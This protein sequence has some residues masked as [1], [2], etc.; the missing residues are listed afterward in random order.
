MRFFIMKKN[1]KTLNIFKIFLLT[2]MTIT[3]SFIVHYT[4][5]T[6]GSW[7]QLNFITIVLAAYFFREKGSILVA[8]LSGIILGPF[9]PNNR[10][11]NIVQ[12]PSNWLFRIFIYIFIAYFVSFIF[13]QNDKLNKKI[14]DSQYINQ[15]TGLY[16][17]NKLIKDLHQIILNNECFFILF[18]KIK[19]LD[20]ISKYV[21]SNIIDE[22]I[23][24]GLDKAKE[25]YN[26][27]YIYSLNSDEY[28][29]IVKNSNEKD[30][31][32]Q[33]NF[34]INN[35]RKPIKANNHLISLVIKV[36]LLLYNG[37]K[38][39]EIEL[40]NRVKIAADQGEFYE[41]GIYKYDYQLKKEKIFFHEISSSLNNS[42]INNEMYLVYQPIV[43]INEN[44]ISSSEVLIRWNRGEKEAVG[45]NIF[46]KIAEQTG[47]INT[48]T[49]WITTTSLDQYI[50]L[51]NRG[52][53]IK[54]SINVTATELI[55]ESFTN[56]FIKKMKDKKINC[57]NFGIE[58]TERVV[59]KD[60]IKLRDNLIKLQNNN[61]LVEIDDFGTGYN[62]LMNL[63]EIP[64]DII[65]IDKYFIDK[66]FDQEM[67]I[68]IRE[69][70]SL[71]HSIGRKVIAEGVET[72]E[73]FLLLKELKCDKIQGYYFS[74]PLEKDSFFN[75]CKSFDIN[76]YL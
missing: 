49:N 41:S 8:L 28:I 47:F 24:N 32:D 67:K 37:E 23:K 60:N 52:L 27:N 31:R 56:Q 35:Y 76:K 46:I 38:I 40:I 43:D 65:K 75:Y 50:E 29:I 66:I 9:M 7:S 44:L 33:I 63:G 57:N 25:I 21:D 69:L 58:I 39:S 26:L 15:F 48:L 12:S 42:I 54:Q 14:S 6:S 68:I 74:E 10:F 5:G 55:D 4:G 17:S 30:I 11:L 2:A 51:K 22:L 72:K 3:V 13:K 34:F 71:I 59:S 62:S 64:F 45:P 70:I 53:D 18:Y 36:G 73:Q 61:V 1:N 20:E 19:N 16:N